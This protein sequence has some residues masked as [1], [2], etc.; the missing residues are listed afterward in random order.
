ME[1]IYGKSPELKHYCYGIH[2]DRRCWENDCRHHSLKPRKLFSSK[3]GGNGL[4]AL[5]TAQKTVWR[6]Q[7]TCD[8]IVT[9]GKLG[10]WSS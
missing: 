7:F 10:I 2:L 6:C 4:P 5:V 1:N 3:D 9:D 8:N